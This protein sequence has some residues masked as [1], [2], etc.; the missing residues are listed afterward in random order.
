MPQVRIYI[1]KKIKKNQQIFLDKKLFTLFENVMRTKNEQNIIIF[2]DKEEW[3][4]NFSEKI[5]FYI[6]PLEIY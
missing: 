3:E 1:Q 5:N 4:S 2:N 6:K